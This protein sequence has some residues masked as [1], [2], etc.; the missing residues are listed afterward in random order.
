MRSVKLVELKEEWEHIPRKRKL[1]ERYAGQC[2]SVLGR[3]V[4]FVRR[5]NDKVDEI[6][7]VTHQIAQGFMDAESGR[8]VSAK[9][10]NDTLKLLR[11]T[12]KYLLPAGAVNPFYNM[13]TKE[14]DTIFR[15]PFTPEELK[16]I[17]DAAKDDDFIRPI[18]V[19]GMCTAMRRGDCCLLKWKDVDLARRFI[20]VK[21][22]KTGGTV[23]IPIF[24]L[25]LDEL[26]SLP[27]S[28]L[29]LPSGKDL[30][31]PEQAGMYEENPD[32][33]TW[34]VKKVLAMALGAMRNGPGERPP[35]GKQNGELR[36]AEVPEEEARRRGHEFIGKLAES[37]KKRRMLAVFDAYMDGKKTS[38]VVAA[39]GVSKGSV[40]GYL[41]E[42]EAAV[43]CKIVRG[44]PEGGSVTA[45]LKGDSSL[46]R[47]KRE[48]G[49]RRASVRDFHSFR[50]T[51]VTLALTAGVP[52]E[53][54]QKVTGRK[55]TDIVLKDYFPLGRDEF[56]QTLQSAVPKL[57]T[58]GH[59]TA[60]E[61]M[62][63]LIESVKPKAL[64]ER[65]M[66]VWAKW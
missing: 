48:D 40:S 64:R 7:H 59:K 49:E 9:T 41:N 18:I 31:F 4:E 21:T 12:F 54:V 56:R 47:V 26:A 22:A 62:R 10:W 29:D 52:L 63:E 23:N 14:T 34:R 46:L 44:R 17:L 43:G 24:P 50:V 15:K 53:L 16:A 3:F 11:T 65:L 66:E 42:I 38:E 13:V 28:K 30:V 60:M 5:Q 27:A 61:E 19:T 33:I 25:L 39:A 55:T 6:T 1:D 35:C 20:T 32:G 8:E 37:D 58:N 51:W 2:K 57:F 45:A 36:L